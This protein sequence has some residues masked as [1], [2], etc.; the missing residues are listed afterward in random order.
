LKALGFAAAL[1]VLPAVALAQGQ[2]EFSVGGGVG[3]SFTQR[4]PF[5]FDGFSYAGGY[6]TCSPEVDAQRCALA[7]ATDF[8]TGLETK[9]PAFVVAG[10]EARRG[11]GGP[12]LLGAGLLGGVSLRNQRVILGDSG[13]VVEGRPPM[14]EEV[15][16]AAD[17]N[18]TFSTNGVGG[19]AYLH[20]GLRWDRGF[21]SRT[22]I[23]YRP[24]GTRVFAE[25]GAGWLAAV[26]GG[27]D[28]GIG[29]PLGIH[30]VA[31]ITVRRANARSLTFSLRHVRAVG[32]DDALLVSSQLSW[33]VFQVGW[34]SD[35]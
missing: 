35:R 12:F 6:R 7:G 15:F 18:A 31:G 24:S 1:A 27:G 10:L 16:N 13:E 2:V 3:S 29:H 33:T 25:A 20:A 34:L 4:G 21:E 8:A 17:S 19:L 14:T 28:A 26:P 23:G 22:T 32:V 11:V 9:Y 5:V 30:A